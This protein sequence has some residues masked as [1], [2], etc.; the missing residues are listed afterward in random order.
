MK[1]LLFA[2]AMICSLQL[3]YAQK[4]DAEMQKAVDKALAATQDAK[5]AA[6]SGTWMN[7][8]KAYQAAY[9][10]PVANLTP[11]ID[12]TTFLMMNKEAANLPVNQVVLEGRSFE[13]IEMDH[14]NIYFNADGILEIA[15]RSRGTPRIAN[16]YLRRIRDYETVK[17]KK[18][19]ITKDVAASALAMLEVDPQGLDKIDRRLLLAV[20][21]KFSGG[22]V[23]LDNLAA[24]ISEDPEYKN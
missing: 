1:K 10:N 18:G 5:K 23:G 7:L 2:L 17:V 16:R 6:K 14:A 19:V 15:R 3:A 12:K 9:S 11:G 21:D 4:P 20:L 8:G 24:T 22:P 13:K